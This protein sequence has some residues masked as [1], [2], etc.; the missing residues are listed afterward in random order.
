MY[1]N[2][3][4]LNQISA[5]I[6]RSGTR[7]RGCCEHSLYEL[8]GQR[9][10]TFIIIFDLKVNGTYYIGFVKRSGATLFCSPL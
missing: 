9:F 1:K 7:G 4:V 5:R 6:H 8:L 10:Y 2:Q 3:F